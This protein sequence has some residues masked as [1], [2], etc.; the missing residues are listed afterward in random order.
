MLQSTCQNSFLEDCVKSSPL[1]LWVEQRVDGQAF[2]SLFRTILAVF[3]RAARLIL[4]EL[5][6][7]GCCIVEEPLISPPKLIGNKRRANFCH[8]KAPRIIPGCCICVYFRITLCKC[9]NFIGKEPLFIK[10]I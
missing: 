6:F 4:R 7:S 5:S 8:T 10:T 9:L 2:V 1:V 3:V